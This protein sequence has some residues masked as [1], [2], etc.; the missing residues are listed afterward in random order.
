VSLTREEIEQIRE[1][2]RRTL[3]LVPVGLEAAPLGFLRSAETT[4][5]TCVVDFVWLLKRLRRFKARPIRD[6]DYSLG[7]ERRH[8]G[9]WCGCYL[10]AV[11]ADD[12]AEEGESGA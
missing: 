12:G 9:G 6:E 5:E 7:D 3:A 8:A 11:E 1:A 2:N 10:C 4:L